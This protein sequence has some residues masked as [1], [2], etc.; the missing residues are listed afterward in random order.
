MEAAPSNLRSRRRERKAAGSTPSIPKRL[1]CS[2]DSSFEDV[3]PKK[4]HRTKQP[5]RRWNSPH[6]RS[7]FASG[8][9]GVEDAEPNRPCVESERTCRRSTINRE[10]DKRGGD[11]CREWGVATA[12]QR[13]TRDD[14]SL[15]EKVSDTERTGSSCF[16]T[17]SPWVSPPSSPASALSAEELSFAYVGSLSNGTDKSWASTER[18]EGPEE[19]ILCSNCRAP[20]CS[21]VCACN[22]A[23]YCGTDC[24]S[25][26]VARHAEQ[27][28]A[29]LCRRVDAAM[30][31]TSLS[32]Y[33]HWKPD[34]DTAA[35]LAAAE[36][37]IEAGVAH[38][39]G[40][41]HDQ[42]ETCLLEARCILGGLGEVE[43]GRKH[44][45][46]AHACLQLWKL[47]EMAG[48]RDKS[49]QML[50][51]SLCARGGVEQC[52]DV[53]VA[54]GFMDLGHLCLDL[55]RLSESMDAYETGLKIYRGLHGEMNPD[56]ACALSNIAMV[57]TEREQHCTAA[58]MFRIA[59]K[60]RRNVHGHRHEK[61][62]NES[63]HVL[64]A[65]QML[66]LH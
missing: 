5:G 36:T 65:D 46:L 61:V 44:P 4:V 28:A 56:V 29:S 27:C 47:Y 2:T 13:K 60:I 53:E 9:L 58:K 7:K 41:R 51:E 55:G 11:A 25:A 14:S 33:S 40:G 21:L 19:D 18:A 43:G 37:R 1:V 30:G 34:D 66:V 39:N 6:P 54:K 35:I 48:L 8:I 15:L 32:A 16:F 42:A 26:D 49:V 20:G 57:L 12:T 52:A 17:L 22:E 64:I 3:E 23:R 31:E 62:R 24:Q 10:E 59:L 63:P 45:R 38:M 50:Q